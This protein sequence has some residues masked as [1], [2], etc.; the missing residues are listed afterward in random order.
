M[1]H[2][3]LTNEEL[4]SIDRWLEE[5]GG[6]SKCPPSRSGLDLPSHDVQESVGRYRT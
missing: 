6:P 5:H 2:R 3:R 4:A 1:L